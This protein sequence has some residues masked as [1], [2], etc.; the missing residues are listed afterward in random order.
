[1]SPILTRIP[2]AILMLILVQVICVGFFVG[3]IVSELIF[4]ND[5][6]DS[7]WEVETIAT[8]ALVLAIVL[9]IR[10]LRNIL[11]RNAS[12][13]DKTRRAAMAF[14]DALGIY[15]DRWGLTPTERDVALFT[16]KGMSIAEVARLRGSAEGTVKSHLNAIYKKAEVTGRGAFLALLIDD[17]MQDAAPTAAADPARAIKTHRLAPFPSQKDAR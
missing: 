7:I 1:M 6:E 10:V 16:I 2:A 5:S 9:E 4:E 15:F 14:Q 8:L 3:D 17:L 11:N 12:L 13:E